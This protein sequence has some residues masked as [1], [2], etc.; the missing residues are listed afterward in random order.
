MDLA[1]DIFAETNPAFCACALAHFATAFRARCDSDPELPLAYLALPIALSADLSG[2]FLG[3]NRRTGL[4]EW[5]ERSPEIQVGLAGRVNSSAA[6]ATEAVR[7]GCFSGTLVVG[8]D[9]RLG[10]GARKF[11]RGGI[12]SLSNLPAQSL[13]RADRLGSWFAASGSTIAVFDAM[14][15]TI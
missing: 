11:K 5:L 13:R 7:F 6:I 4:H 10:I 12:V 3:T 9:A 2:A 15:L 14:G 8:G 1:H